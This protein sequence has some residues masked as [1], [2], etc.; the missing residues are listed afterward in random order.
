MPMLVKVI[1]AASI[2]TDE[3]VHLYLHALLMF[4][5]FRNFTKGIFNIKHSEVNTPIIT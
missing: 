2:E 5:S 3:S 1:G 4:S